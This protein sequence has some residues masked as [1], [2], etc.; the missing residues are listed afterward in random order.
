MGLLLCLLL[1]RVRELPWPVPPNP[2]PS[3]P[4]PP[5]RRGPHKAHFTVPAGPLEVR[6][7]PDLGACASIQLGGAGGQ[8]STYDLRAA[9]ATDRHH[10]TLAFLQL[11]P[12]ACRGAE[13]WFSYG[14][15]P[16]GL[17]AV[18]SSSNGCFV[19]ICLLRCTLPLVLTGALPPSPVCPALCLQ[20]AGGAEA[21]P[22]IIDGHGD[23][24]SSNLTC[25]LFQRRAQQASSRLGLQL[26][27]IGCLQDG[28]LRCLASTA[29]PLP[30]TLCLLQS[31]DAVGAGMPADETAS[32]VPDAT[33]LAALAA[34]FAAGLDARRLQRCAEEAGAGGSEGLTR[35]QLEGRAAALF[36]RELLGHLALLADAPLAELQ[37]RL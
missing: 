28:S 6:A 12:G 8:L 18:R 17:L 29:H 26:A 14:I 24:D 21:R 31:G 33:H 3:P 37:V 2:L 35:P 5:S 34:G 16:D 27:A 15:T 9:F 7:G 13:G 4:I 32:G 23:E 36:R 25:L 20:P 19:L 22:N 10:H 1:Q 30:S 11:P